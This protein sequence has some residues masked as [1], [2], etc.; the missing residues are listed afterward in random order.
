MVLGLLL[1]S[2]AYSADKTKMLT[3]FFCYDEDPKYT[4]DVKII[5]PKGEGQKPIMMFNTWLMSIEEETST[6]YSA[7]GDYGD[8]IKTGFI[9]KQTGY[10]EFKIGNTLFKGLCKI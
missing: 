9:N 4:F 7:I 1:S 8:E 5:R 10:F 2:N 3:E 6:Y